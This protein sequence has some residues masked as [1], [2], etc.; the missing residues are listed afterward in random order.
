MQIQKTTAFNPHVSARIMEQ[1]R[2]AAINSLPDKDKE[3]KPI[4]GVKAADKE[5]PNTQPYPAKPTDLRK[6]PRSENLL[7]TSQSNK[8]FNSNLNSKSQHALDAYR[9]HQN[10]QHNEERQQLQQLLGIDHYV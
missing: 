1:K 4:H 8:L 3:I 2:S 6:E 5:Q 9:N 10:M 7:I